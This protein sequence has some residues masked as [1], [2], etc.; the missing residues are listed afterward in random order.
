MS[1]NVV[2]IMQ[3]TPRL[4][5]KFHRAANFE[6]KYQFQKSMHVARSI[7]SK[8]RHQAHLYN[9]L[10]CSVRL[11]R[12]ATRHVSTGAKKK[13]KFETDFSQETPPE[14]RASIVSD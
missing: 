2:C 12:A 7:I 8:L 9:G 1:R 10:S 13:G 3:N 6:K 14:V 5:L 11:H 4:H